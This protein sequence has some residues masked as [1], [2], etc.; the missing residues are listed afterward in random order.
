[1]GNGF[2]S[3]SS[4]V[5]KKIEEARAGGI[6]SEVYWKNRGF[7]GGQAQWFF[8]YA[9]FDNNNYFKYLFNMATKT[10]KNPD[11]NT[12][13]K[14]YWA[15]NM[16]ADMFDA[17]RTYQINVALNAL[18]FA[19][20]DPWLAPEVAI[21]EDAIIVEDVGKISLDLLKTDS[22]TAFFWSG[23]TD[24][25]GGADRALEIANQNGGTTLEGLIESKGIEMP[26]YD[27]N[28]PASVK[29]WDDVSAAY[30]SQVS[31]IVRAVVGTTLR[32]NNIW[33]NIELPRL[34]LNP[35]VSEIIII[36]PMTLV[37]KVIMSR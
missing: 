32:A 24:G 13:G 25:I 4:T 15:E 6:N 29:A 33:Q 31:G 3:P 35:N 23:R 17:E 37:E 7:L 20:A 8:P 30:A 18:A 36:D 9:G 10:S 1:M 27:V 11:D 34:M 16:I 5:R 2:A 19:T 26:E 12:N 14:A 22:S 28:N 21:A